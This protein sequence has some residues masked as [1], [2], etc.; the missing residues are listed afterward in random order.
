MRIAAMAAVLA[1]LGGTAVQAQDLNVYTTRQ[2]SLLKPLFDQFTKET[3]VRVNAVFANEGLAE[4]IAA[5]GANSPADLLITVDIGSL[6]QAKDL[7]ITQPISPDAV[8]ANVPANLRDPDGHWTALSMRARVVYASRERVAQ[9]EITYEELADPKWRGKICTRPGS[10]VYNIGMIA[11]LVAHHGEQWTEN[12]LRG[13]KQN[14][15]AKPAGNDRS[16]AKAIYAGE[17]ELAFANTYYYGLMATNEKEPEQKEW[18]KAIKVLFPNASGR[19]THVNVSG[20]ALAKH[21]PHKDTALKFLAFLTG[22]DAQRIYAEINHEYPVK[23]GVP[24]SSLIGGL[25]QMK[26]D[27]IPL[28]DIAKQRAKAGELVDK[29]GFDQGPSS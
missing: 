24:V 9:N 14:L 1:A 11:S 17:C 20:A 6:Q 8:T 18:A 5:E 2:P 10:H 27:A 7:G 15:T 12:W 4:R 21:A 3:G 16:Q 29:T 19:G 13:V 28:V 26:P 22:A 23:P 25:G